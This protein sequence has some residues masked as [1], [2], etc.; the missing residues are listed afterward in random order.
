MFSEN[1]CNT[2]LEQVQ[3]LDLYL[4]TNLLHLYQDGQVG[5]IPVYYSAGMEACYLLNWE[6]EI[7]RSF[8]SPQMGAWV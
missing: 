5:K 2:T 6:Q 8:N 7:S 3:L 1:L 4:Y